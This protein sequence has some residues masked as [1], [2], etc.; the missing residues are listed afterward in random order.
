MAF[1]D[2]CA[3][4]ARVAARRAVVLA[5]VAAVSSLAAGSSP[6]RLVLGIPV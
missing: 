3:V 1:A 5:V 4:T 2:F 6:R